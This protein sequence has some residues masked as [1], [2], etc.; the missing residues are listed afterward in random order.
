MDV[1][2][3]NIVESTMLS[4]CREMGITMMKTSY[5]TIF[6]ESLDFSC[7]IADADGEMIAV[8]DY[9]PA[10]IGG[11]T[12]LIKSCIR[13]MADKPVHEGDVILHNDPYRGGLHTPEHTFFTPFFVDGEFM[14]YAV[15][16]GH[17]AEVGG[18]VPGGFAS[19]ATEIF[20]EGL[21]VPPVKI[22]KQGRDVDEV[23][24]LLL[25]NVRTPR[26]NYGDYRSMI[27]A[28][29]LGAGR[30]A[31]LIRKYGKPLFR[32]TIADLM[33]Y[34]ESRMR[35][36]I[37]AIPDGT[38]SFEDY[39]ED[40]G[41][42]PTPY[43]IAVD[44]VVQGDE[45][46]ADFGRSDAQAKGA[47]NATLGVTCSATYNAMLH[48]TDPSIPRNAGCYRPIRV[49]ARPAT[50]VN[51]DFPAP[52]VGGNTETHVRIC[53]TVIA[54]MS[55]CLPERA[56]A[57]D[58]G[59]HGNFLFGGHDPRTTSSTSATTS[60]SRAGAGAPSPTATTPATALTATAARCRSRSTR[61]AIPG[62][63]RRSRSPRIRA[64]PASTGAGSARPRRWNARPTRSSSATWPTATEGAVG[65]AWRRRRGLGRAAREEGERV[66]VEGRVRGLRQGL[67]EQVRQRLHPPRRP[68]APQVGRRRGLRPGGRTGAR[69]GG[70]RRGRGLRL[71]ERRRRA[72][73]PRRA[74]RGV[75]ASVSRLLPGW[76]AGRGFDILRRP[77]APVAGEEAAGVEVLGQRRRI[78]RAA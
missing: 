26:Y 54:A 34:S 47:I 41:I 24:K 74:S 8:A 19:E 45:I 67:A 11:M 27:S 64:A 63:W 18:M 36:E 61:A 39:M 62:S 43:R 33:D 1:V 10:Q 59:T 6:N 2:T 73:R 52:E 15:A 75:A 72:L 4:I 23:W 58:A 78:A 9:C 35:A 70:G 53:Y 7:A 76:P 48:L 25:A 13:E 3:M 44:M 50:V 77:A 14:G 38:Y 31:G 12:L 71:S 51:V 55:R 49:L 20:H 68:G 46:V 32:Q 21:R 30:M 65:P 37:A 40:D 5:S 66:R 60:W 57:T 56:F 16:I 22:K 17:V 69:A 42:D 29:E 28:C